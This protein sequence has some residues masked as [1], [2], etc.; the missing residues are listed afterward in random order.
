MYERTAED[1]AVRVPIVALPDESEEK[2]EEYAR[3]ISVKK[4]VEV[5]LVASKFVNVEVAVEVAVSFPTVKFEVVACRA[6]IKVEVEKVHILFQAEAEEIIASVIEP[7]GKEIDEVAVIEPTV[8]LPMEEVAVT[9]PPS[10]LR[11]VVVAFANTPPQVVEVQ[12]NGAPV[13][14][15]LVMHE[16]PERQSQSVEIPADVM[17]GKVEVAVVE[18]AVIVPATKPPATD[19][20]A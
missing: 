19:S 17:R 12:A 4:L 20:F 6:Y 10:S 2:I 3:K 14:A 7:D 18:V 16:S 11:S 5:A 1:V 8:R 9:R 13:E 15:Q